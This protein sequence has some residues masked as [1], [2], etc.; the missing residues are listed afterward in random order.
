MG[1]QDNLDLAADFLA[2]TGV[3]TPLMIWD[4]GF[5]SWIYYGVTGQPTAI[6]VDA[7]GNPIQG[8][9]GRF[10]TDEVLQ[11]AAAA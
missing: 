7:E 5:E 4:P 6:L 2:A 3:S 10:D 1:A 11:L 8:W 9:R